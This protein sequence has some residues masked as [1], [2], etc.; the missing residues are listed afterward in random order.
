MRLARRRVRG[1]AGAFLST[2]VEGVRSMSSNFVRGRLARAV[3]RTR[4]AILR[5][6]LGRSLTVASLLAACADGPRAEAPPP[7]AAP[8]PY[9]V[10][11]PP[12]SRV[13][14]P[15]LVKGFAPKCTPDAIA[16][17]LD[18]WVKVGCIVARDASMR[19]CRVLEGHPFM[20]DNTLRAAS[21]TR[22]EPATLDG[23]PVDFPLLMPFHFVCVRGR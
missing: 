9:E 15:R 8:A 5:P 12:G 20:N 22:F 6:T 7:P 18:V 4:E 2:G 16:H 23:E 11:T 13:V 19:E 10:H 3:E 17:Q 14:P 21:S 1:V